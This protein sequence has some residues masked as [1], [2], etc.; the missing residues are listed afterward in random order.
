VPQGGAEGMIVTRGGRFGG[1]GLYLL[2]G[3]PV[4][5]WNLLDLERV[6]WEGDASLSPGKHT[7]TYD[8]KYDGLGFAT[9]AFNNITGIGRSGTGTFSVDGKVVATKPM[10]KTVPLTLPWDETI[11]VGSDT[12]TPVDD[13]D[14]AVPF[15]FTG[16]LDKLTINVARP[17]LTADDIKKLAEA[18]A[19]VNDSVG[20]AG[21]AAV[22]ASAPAGAGAAAATN[23]DLSKLEACRQKAKALDLDAIAR[24]RFTIDCVR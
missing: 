3:K 5:T 22:P 12:G 23:V 7:I 11:D 24:L 14:Y 6:K 1:Y 20:P 8:F 4:F 18:E 17:D 2:K 9:L 13:G 15:T 16:K 10:P 21:S 19:A